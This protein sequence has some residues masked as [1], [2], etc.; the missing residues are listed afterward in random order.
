M[1][2]LADESEGAAGIAQTLGLVMQDHPNRAVI[3]RVRDGF[4]PPLDFQVTAQCWRPFGRQRQICCEQIEIAASDAALADLPS[5]V[6]PLAAPDLPVI[7]W[8]RSARLFEMPPFGAI[9]GMA[10]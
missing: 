5:V 1:I 9:A 2:V 7:V 4:E 6:L 8:S 3:V 10:A